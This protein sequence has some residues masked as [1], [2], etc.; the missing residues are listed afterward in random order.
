MMLQR[1]ANIAPRLLVVVVA[2]R[3]L[4]AKRSSPQRGRQIRVGLQLQRCRRAQRRLETV[5]ELGQIEGDPDAG[6]Y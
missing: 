5:D 2:E 4:R 6:C 1:N 3:F